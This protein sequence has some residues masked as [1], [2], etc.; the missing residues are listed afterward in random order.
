M[1]NNFETPKMPEVRFNKTGTVL[2]LSGYYSP[3]VWA[4]PWNNTTGFGTIYSDPA[5]QLTNALSNDVNF[6]PSND[7]IAVNVAG[8]PQII[9]YRWN[10]STGFGTRYSNPSVIPPNTGQ[11]VV[12]SP[13][14]D[15]IVVG[16]G[17][18]VIAYPWNY[19]TGFGTNYTSPTLIASG[20]DCREVAF[21][22]SGKAIAVLT[23]FTA[24]YFAVYAC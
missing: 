7:V 10:D 18:G 16:T 22:P 9:C 19:S 23:G 8:S 3:G 24:P 14:G 17:S 5:P 6:S 15:A 2:G 11:T 20:I 13:S 12:F 4:F 21:H 1:S